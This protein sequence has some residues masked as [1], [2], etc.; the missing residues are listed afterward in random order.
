M[1]PVTENKTFEPPP[2]LNN[3]NGDVRKA[4]F[5]FE[6]SGVT[7]NVAAMHVRKVFGGEHVIHSTFVHSVRGTRFGTFSVEMD[8]TVL[9]DKT[10]EKP[11]RAV[12]LHPR[13]W[14]AKPLEQAI[15]DALPS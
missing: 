3:A 5:E 8:T 2:A 4:G 7:L 1:G 13:R 10:Y 6:F 9:K 14:D 12:G 15:L 11:L